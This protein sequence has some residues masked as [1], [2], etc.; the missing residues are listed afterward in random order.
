MTKKQDIRDPSQTELRDEAYQ[1][2]GRNLVLFQKTE[3]MLKVLVSRSKIGGTLSELES[4]IKKRDKAVHS[5]G[6]GSLVSEFMASM[7]SFFTFSLGMVF[8]LGTLFELSGFTSGFRCLDLEVFLARL[9][10]CQGS[11]VLKQHVVA[12]F[13]PELVAGLY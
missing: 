7:H 13:V 11:V 3:M 8:S 9:L 5:H 12:L 4:S 2:I 1:K 10:R 6:M